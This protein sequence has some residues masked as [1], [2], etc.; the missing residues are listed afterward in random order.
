MIAPLL[1]LVSPTE[2]SPLL[3]LAALRTLNTVADSFFLSHPDHDTT[4]DELLSLLYTE[5]YLPNLANL[6]LQA[7]R[8]STV[9]QQIALTAALISKTCREEHHRAMLAQSG[10]LEALAVKLASFVVATGC[11]LSP[12]DGCGSGSSHLGDIPPATSRSRM[13][14]ILQAIGSIIKCSKL[15]AIQFISAPAF[16]SILQKPDADT[17]LSHE[18]RGNAWV[19]TS[20]NVLNS[21]Q[22]PPIVIESLIPPLPSSHFRSSLAPT[23]NFPPLGALGASGKQTQASKSFSSAVEVIQSQSLEFIDEEESLLIPWLLYIARTESEV[24]GLM[25]ARVLAILHRHGLTKRGREM[26]FALLLV[27]SVVRLLDKDLRISSEASNTNDISAL[28]SPEQFIKQHA[29]PVLAMLSANSLEIQ[30]AAAEAGA[31]KKLSQLLKESYDPVTASSSTSLWAP[32]PS[33]SG[34]TETREDASTLGAAGVSATAYHVMRLRESVLLALAA[35][36]SDKDEYRRAI[37]DNGVIPFVVKTLKPED[38]DS[39]MLSLAKTQVDG[40]SKNQEIFTGNCKDAILAACGA[41]RALSR[42]VV[43]LRTSLMDAGL[44]TPLFALLKNQDI[45]LQIEATAVV[46]NLVLEFSPMREVN[47]K[48]PVCYQEL[49]AD[50]LA[51]YH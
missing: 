23:P 19:S 9:Q 6:L 22:P 8:S 35:I 47:F 27:P 2:S 50:L 24:T 31:I 38:A 40:V 10:V 1:S 3:V 49:K 18:R 30:K 28:T 48:S 16:S 20:S 4:D 5:Q 29:P 14:P 33:A 13:S 17:S 51:G 37:I 39:S 42:S 45:E 41:A 32:D 43:T 34:Y 15:R 7:S 44:A 46:C 12:N 26:W 11:S 25:A 36:A 21:R